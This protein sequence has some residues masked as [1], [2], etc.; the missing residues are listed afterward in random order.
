MG[1]KNK[2]ISSKADS[3]KENAKKVEDIEEIEELDDF[4]DIED[5]EDF[6]DIEE[7]DDFE[8]IEELD[9]FDDIENIEDIDDAEEELES[10]KKDSKKHEEIKKTDKENHKKETSKKKEESKKEDNK[11]SKTEKN[12]DTKK[13]PV[14]KT[15]KNKAD[16]EGSSIP[17]L[18]KI[19]AVVVIAIIVIL[20]LLKSC[21]KT[22]YT[23]KFSTD[24]GNE[25]SEQVIAKDNKVTPPEDPTK[26]GYV[27][28]GWYVGDEKYDFDSKVTKDLTIEARWEVAANKD[29]TGITVDQTTITLLPGDNATLVAT[30]EPSD[31]KNKAVIWSSADESIVTVDENGTITA[32]KVGK[33]TVTVTTKEGN[34]KAEVEVIVS[35]DVVT[36]EGVSLDKTKVNLGTGKTV[37]LKATVKPADASD[38]GVTWKSNNEKVAKVDRNGKVTAVGEGT[39]TITVITNDGGHKATAT[40]IVKNVAVTKVTVNKTAITLTEGQTQKVVATVNPTDATNKA[41]TW[42]SNNTGVA[43]VDK[44]GNIKGI[45][46]GTAVITVKTKDGNKTATVKVTVK[47]PVRAESVT[48]SGNTTGTE[49]GTIRLTA[50]VKPNDAI[51]ADKKVTWS[52]NNTGIATVSSNGVVTLK[53]AGTVVITA[54]TGNGKTATITITVKEKP[55]SYRVVLKAEYTGTEISAWLLTAYKNGAVMAKSTFKGITCGGSSTSSASS[56]FGTVASQSPTC[57]ITLSDGSKVNATAEWKK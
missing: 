10:K 43:T 2:K 17:T 55:A 1:E 22:E 21:Q 53:K 57:T 36:A 20:L 38:K 37:T 14:A 6:D 33:T 35:N 41:V 34:F 47:A 40:I 49:G 51:A 39:A 18:A 25:I 28:V 23:V 15:T 11:A 16:E 50:T 7:L 19:A 27:F 52:S 26:E 32:K 44:N 56:K 30:V 31:A 29:V 46:E 54:R 3:V 9:D 45:K 24:G 42:S 5:I 4:E 13:T 48:I 8:D 12:K